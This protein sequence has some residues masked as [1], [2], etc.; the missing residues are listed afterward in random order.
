MI[1]WM[2][3]HR[4][5]FSFLTE[6]SID[7]ADDEQLLGLMKKAGFNHVFVGIETPSEEGL[8][9]CNKYHNINRNL[10]ASV[11]KIQ[12]NGMQ[13]SAGFIVGFDSDTVSIFERQIDFI[14]HSGIIIAMVGLLNAVKG[15]KLYAR[16][17]KEE[18]L[19]KDNSGNNTD[20]SLN[21]IPKMNTQKLL[22]GYRRIVTTVY[23]S[24]PFYDRVMLFFREYH[25]AKSPKVRDFRLYYLKALI[26]S[27]Y[28]LGIREKDRK[29]YWNFLIK[30]LLRY[31]RF[32]PHAFTFA[33][34]GFH[35]RKVFCSQTE[36]NEM[37]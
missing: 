29:E 16:L 33:I 11:R 9:E 4:Y 5:P 8:R 13:V 15:T 20:Y 18:R 10:L 26:K 32:L 25:P 27:I 14:Q 30:T 7:L 36:E 34:Y 6:V 1:Q 23:S 3:K 2:K 28:H 19:L 35:F 17:K 22:D 12:N 37:S 21:F 31:P 24:R